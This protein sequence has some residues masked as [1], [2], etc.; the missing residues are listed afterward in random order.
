MVGDL[1]I[2]PEKSKLIEEGEA[3][4]DCPVE[5]E[6]V[7]QEEAQDELLGDYKGEKG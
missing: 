2:E 3:I 4:E 5:Q 6:D 1:A 7:E